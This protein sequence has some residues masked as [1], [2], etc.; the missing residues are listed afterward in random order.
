[1]KK[2]I[3][4][5]VLL[6]AAGLLAFSPMEPHG[7]KWWQSDK[8]AADLGLT[9]DQRAR[10]DKLMFEHRDQV[11]DLRAALEKAELR[12]R[13]LMDD[14][15]FNERAALEQLDRVATARSLVE[16]SRA[17]MLIK[18]RSILTP[19]Q[20]SKA[21]ERLMENRRERREEMR[22]FRQEHRHGG[23]RDRRRDGSCMD[24]PTPDP[25][26]AE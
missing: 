24:I 12:L 23:D 6:A 20:W 7:G 10:L 4:C 26:D 25:P 2:L 18:T 22:E 14:P 5:T 15:A 21:R 11:I 17:A 1:M 13:E 9:P 3:L 19:E 16:K 8:A